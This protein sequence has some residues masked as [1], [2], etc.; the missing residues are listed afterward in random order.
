MD[1]NRP[2]LLL[3]TYSSSASSGDRISLQKPGKIEGGGE[4]EATA[5]NQPTG[6]I[7]TAVWM[8]V[9]IGVIKINDMKNVHP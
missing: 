6:P 5:T 1:K 4:P 8:A 7:S 9:I 2:P 3:V